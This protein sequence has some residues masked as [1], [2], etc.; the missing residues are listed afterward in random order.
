MK[1]LRFPFTVDTV[2]PHL[3]LSY[4]PDG[5]SSAVVTGSAG[6]EEEHALPDVDVQLFSG[7]SIVPGQTPLVV[8]TVN[9]VGKA[10][11]ATFAGLSPGYLYG[12]R[13]AV[14]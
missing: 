8:N 1:R 3:T 5:S 13:R 9:V 7:S 4:Q 10:W 11:S 14:R 12:S 6:T 2:P